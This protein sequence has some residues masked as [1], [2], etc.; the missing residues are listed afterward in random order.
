MAPNTDTLRTKRGKLPVSRTLYSLAARSL[1]V[2]NHFNRDVAT[3][4]LVGAQ[5]ATYSVVGSMKRKLIF[6]NQY[7]DLHIGYFHTKTIIPEGAVRGLTMRHIAVYI[8]PSA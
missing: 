6:R 1:D 5:Q 4:Y 3:Y 8:S 2:D 7:H